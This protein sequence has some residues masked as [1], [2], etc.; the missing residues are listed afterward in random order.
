MNT[1]HRARPK[2]RGDGI[3]CDCD[4]P[5]PIARLHAEPDAPRCIECQTLF[6]RKEAIRVGFHR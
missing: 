2:P 6:E 4:E 1:Y 3:C 5:I